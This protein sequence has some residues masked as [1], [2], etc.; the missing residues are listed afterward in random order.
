[1]C[2]NASEKGLKLLWLLSGLTFSSTKIPQ[3]L[4][5]NL[6]AG[7]RQK[8]QDNDKVVGRDELGIICVTF[9]GCKCEVN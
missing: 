1:M 5:V 3:R 8:E 9:F 7:A 4:R 6:L 2:T